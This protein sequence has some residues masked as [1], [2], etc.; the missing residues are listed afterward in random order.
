MEKKLKLHW[1]KRSKTAPK[2]EISIRKQMI[3]NLL[4]FIYYFYIFW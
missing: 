2:N 4:L 1:L 3:Q